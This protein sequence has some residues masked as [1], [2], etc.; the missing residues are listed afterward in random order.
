M[1][2]RTTIQIFWKYDEAT[3]INKKKRMQNYLKQTK[4]LATA[5]INKIFEK[6]I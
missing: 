3:K 2:S 6:E 4:E 1:K 5:F